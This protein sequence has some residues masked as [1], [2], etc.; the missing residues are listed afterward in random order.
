MP[1]VRFQCLLMLELLDETH[2]DA[3]SFPYRQLAYP[4]NP[5]AGLTFAFINTYPDSDTLSPRRWHSR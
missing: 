1:I 4:E 2:K 5:V 3:E